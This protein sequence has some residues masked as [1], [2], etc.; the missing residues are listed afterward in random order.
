MSQ[1]G[2]LDDMYFMHCEDIDWCMRFRQ[3]GWKILFV[4]NNEVVHYKGTCS[5]SRPIRVLYHMHRSMIRFYR[6][7]FRHKY[8]WPLLAVVIAAAATRFV[9]LAASELLGRL[10]SGDTAESSTQPPKFRE[11]RNPT[12]VVAYI[13]P[14]RRQPN[15]GHVL[16]KTLKAPETPDR[17]TSRSSSESEIR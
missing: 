4:P 17:N 5:K 13:G 14:D 2:P 16:S 15:R 11:R 7:F 9:A 3:A 10:L 6:K 1:V 8:P 12:P